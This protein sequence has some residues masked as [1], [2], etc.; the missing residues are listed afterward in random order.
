MRFYKTTVGLEAYERVDMH[1]IVV[2]DTRTLYSV[3]SYYL[4]FPQSFH[5]FWN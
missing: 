4:N 1:V 5:I 3:V 2:F